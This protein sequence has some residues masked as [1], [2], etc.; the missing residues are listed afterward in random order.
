MLAFKVNSAESLFYCL[1]DYLII[2]FY[3]LL[4]CSSHSD[5]TWHW[6]KLVQTNRL[7][8]SIII[9]LV[10]IFLEDLV[11][12]WLL[13]YETNLVHRLCKFSRKRYKKY[14]ICQIEC[15]QTF[16]ATKYCFLVIQYQHFVYDSPIWLTYELA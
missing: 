2:S 13:I 1:C 5:Y 4:N 14:I 9:M 7:L 12:V 11:F 16:G 8:L 10:F 6:Q 15:T 3:Y